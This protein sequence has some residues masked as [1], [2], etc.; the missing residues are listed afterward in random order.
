MITVQFSAHITAEI[1]IALRHEN[2]LYLARIIAKPPTQSGMSFRQ[3]M[4]A[5]NMG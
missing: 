2:T 5:S 3:I 4:I 1:S